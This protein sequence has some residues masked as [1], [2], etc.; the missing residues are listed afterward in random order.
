MTE[1]LGQA[2]RPG[3]LAVTAHGNVYLVDQDN[4]DVLQLSF[5][6]EGY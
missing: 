1:R 4:G 5:A 6:G 2:V 3:R